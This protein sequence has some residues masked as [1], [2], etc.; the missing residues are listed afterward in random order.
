MIYRVGIVT[1][2]MEFISE[3]FFTKGEAETFILEISETKKI[4][5]CRLKN[6]ETGEEEKVDI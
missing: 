6:L 2:Q 4:K 1:E 5:N 3:N